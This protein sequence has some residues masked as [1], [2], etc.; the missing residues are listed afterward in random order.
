MDDLEELEDVRN[1]SGS[2]QYLARGLGAT[3]IPSCHRYR[4]S[5]VSNAAN[6]RSSSLPYITS[7]HSAGHIYYKIK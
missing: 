4:A 2:K 1:V 5:S 6:G 7:L 3:P